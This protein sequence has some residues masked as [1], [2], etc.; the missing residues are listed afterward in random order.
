MNEL[1]GVSTQLSKLSTDIDSNNKNIAT[2]NSSITN[3]NSSITNI[4][5]R[6]ENKVENTNTSWAIEACSV[7]YTK[8]QNITSP[9]T[10]PADGV[11]RW[12]KNA[13]SNATVNGV[14]VGLGGND[15]YNEGPVYLTVRKGDV[16]TFT[17]DTNGYPNFCPYVGNE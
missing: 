12:N 10:A 8:K 2:I 13:S 15:S 5:T 11:C 3:I 6:L 7:D 17:S 14:E 16:I 1:S 9:F 4:N